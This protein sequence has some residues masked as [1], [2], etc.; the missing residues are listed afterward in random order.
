[1][2]I[3]SET[4]KKLRDRTGAGM[5]DCKRALESTGGDME[6]AI[7][8][9][10]KKGAAVGAKRADRAA[11][12]GTIVTRVSP[13]GTSGVILEVNC[14][15]DFVGRSDDFLAF[16]GTVAAV[17]Q[18]HKP[19][20]VE[21]LA[22]LHAEGKTIAELQNDILAKVGEKIDI[23]RFQV[24]DAPDGAVTAYTHVGGKIGVLV[25]LSGIPAPEATTGVGRD[26]AMQIAAMNPSVVSRD[27]VDQTS[28]AREL[29]VYKTQAKNEGKPEHIL[30]KIA[31]GRLEK[32]FQEVCLVEQTFIKDGTKTVKD[33]LHEA[34]ARTGKP[35]AVKR[36]YRFHLGE[37]VK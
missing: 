12:E 19:A 25:E 23:R 11:K 7:D 27:Q 8:Y 21:Q 13:D 5:M 18:L 17:V 14:E 22:G 32:F 20:N 15:T 37:E 28:I 36:F 31:T 24:V 3:T 35:V 6:K 26:V 33:I 4:I 34:S 1:M 30:E 16:A 2:D 10:R 9:L 29:E